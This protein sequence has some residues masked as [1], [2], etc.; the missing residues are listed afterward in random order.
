MIKRKL[1]DVFYPPVIKHKFLF[2]NI[3]CD[4]RMILLN[5][6]Q[7]ICLIKK[8]V[9]PTPVIRDFIP[10]VCLEGPMILYIMSQT[11]SV[12]SKNFIHMY[13]CKSFTGSILAFMSKTVKY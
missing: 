3:L 6:R 2:V 1:A 7:C 5:H 9:C 12:I 8:S 13:T 11:N 4:K 10:S